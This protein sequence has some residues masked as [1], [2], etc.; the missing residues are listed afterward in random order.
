MFSQNKSLETMMK[1]L[2]IFLVAASS[3]AFAVRDPVAFRPTSTLA[4]T[5]A[6]RMSSGGA[7]SVPELKPPAALYQGAVAAGAAKASASWQKIFKL[8]IASGC[9]IGFGY[10]CLLLQL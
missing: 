6:L 2:L 1:L 8:G 3:Y 5:T 7:D 9:H 4:A 10:V